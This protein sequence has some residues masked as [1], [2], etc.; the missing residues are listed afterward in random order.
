MGA[1]IFDPQRTIPVRSEVDVVVVGGGPAGSSAA[2]AAARAGAKTVLI[3]RTGHLGGMATGGMVWMIHAMSDGTKNKLIK[4]VA[5]EWLD[6]LKE[7]EGA[8]VVDDALLG[9]SDEKLFSNWGRM[10][11]YP[12]GRLLYGALFDTEHLKHFLAQMVKESGAKLYLHSLGTRP[13]M[14]DGNVK[15]VL[16]ECKEGTQAIL[17][18]TVIDCTGDGDIFNAAGAQST[19]AVSGNNRL[20][21]QA[22]VF[23]FANVDLEK[24]AKFIAEHKEEYDALMAELAAQNGFT[25]FSK[26]IAQHPGSVHFNM[27][28][29]GYSLLN[30]DDLTAIEVDVRERMMTTFRFYKKRLPGFEN[31]YIM[32]TA[33]QIGARG[34]RRLIGEYTLSEADARS[35][36]MFADSVAEWPPLYGNYPDEP[37][38]FL[39]LRALLPKG[40]I[41]GIMCAG[42]CFS[43]DEIINEH[44]NTISHCTSMGQAAGVTAAIAAQQGATVRSVDRRL[45]QKALAA[46]GVPLPSLK[47]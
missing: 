3:E 16:F 7:S 15:G 37:H 6:R 29:E 4:G 34:S 41:E 9:S 42:R 11:F 23:E 13:I 17:A 20:D 36:E 14:E 46:Q 40:D 1:T 25:R 28:L 2:I 26:S 45:V 35:G 38:I 8:T 10:F 21:K 39:P 22:L 31:A 5:Q 19:T 30:V 32:V 44:Y 12:Y 47:L 33:P 24:N 27:F 18:K 43:S